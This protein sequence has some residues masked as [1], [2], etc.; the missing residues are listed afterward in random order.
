MRMTD[1]AELFTAPNVRRAK[2]SNSR[3]KGSKVVNIA[4]HLQVIPGSM[5]PGSMYSRLE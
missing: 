4:V 2:R 5:D 3:E 1:P